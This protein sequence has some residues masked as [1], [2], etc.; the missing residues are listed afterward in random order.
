[1]INAKIKFDNKEVMV[2]LQTT[3]TRIKRGVLAAAHYTAPLAEAYMK[4][5]APW[6]DR[7]GAARSG[8]RA[9][10]IPA[11]DKVAIVLYHSVP[12]GVFLE[13]RWGGKYSVIPAAM[14]FTGPLWVKAIQRLAFGG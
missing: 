8:L 3:D 2:N 1:M 11:G 9:T 4:Q 6:T 7:T 5:T 14:A 10:V 13:V 12:Y